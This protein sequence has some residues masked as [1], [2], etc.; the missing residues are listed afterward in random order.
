V[1]QTTS[2]TLEAAADMLLSDGDGAKYS[3]IWLNPLPLSL[4]SLPHT[5]RC[6]QLWRYGFWCLLV[7]SS[8][9]F[10]DPLVLDHSERSGNGVPYA[11]LAQYARPLLVQQLT[12][13]IA[14]F[15]GGIPR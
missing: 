13:D 2:W 4:S 9:D 5:S 6:F 11:P 1:P 14:D 3:T 15:V 8:E 10:V 12:A 7:P